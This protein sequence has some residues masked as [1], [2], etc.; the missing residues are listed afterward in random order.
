[1]SVEVQEQLARK[2]QDAAGTRGGL[3]ERDPEYRALRKLAGRNRKR[4]PKTPTDALQHVVDV[5]RQMTR[6]KY[7]ALAVTGPTDYV[8]GFIVSGMDEKELRALKGPPQGHGPLGNM[9]QD[10]LAVHFEDV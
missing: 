8:E 1:M 3:L 4:P 10:G 6:A 9:R 7:G 5:A 2:V